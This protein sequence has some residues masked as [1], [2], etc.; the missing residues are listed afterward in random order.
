[1]PVTRETVRIL[2]QMRDFASQQFE[3]EKARIIDGESK[4]DRKERIAD[5]KAL[6]SQASSLRSAAAIAGAITLF[7][8]QDGVACD[9]DAFDRD[10]HLLNLRTG[11]LDLRTGEVR[12]HRASDMVTRTFNADYIPGATAP[13]WEQ[14][15]QDVLPDPEVRAY[16]QRALGYT[17]TGRADQ[18][19]LM[20]LYGPSSTGKTQFIKVIQELFGDYGRNAEPSVF[21]WKR[22]SGGPT[23]ELHALRG[24]RFIATSETS[25]SARM[26]E[27]AIKRITGAD[28]VTSRALY[29]GQKEWQ[30]E[31]VVWMATNFPPM[32]NSDDKAMW[33]R[34]KP[35]HFNV[36]FSADGEPDENGNETRRWTANIYKAL[37]EE[38]PGILN[39]ML[40]G[41]RQFNE[42]GQLGEPPSVTQAM[43]E[44]R[45][46]SDSV[47][48]FLQDAESEGEIVHEPGVQADI[49]NIY[50]LYAAWCDANRIPPLGRR[51]MTNR[52]LARGMV[53]AKS[54][55][56]TYWIGVKVTGVH[57]IRGTMP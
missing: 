45:D 48:S 37:L 26:D 41:L 43:L 7:G 34:V 8:S 54:N 52:M 47:T 42:L 17:L 28:K 3:F 44:Q 23:P 27:E 1:V 4:E 22:D 6:K 18:R 49:R 10:L 39:W 12:E 46:G 57:G 29:E 13:R 25:E 36:L 21:R 31:G 24:A 55:G 33:N 16:V 30:P 14:F 38:A 9:S 2:E 53:Q 40:E 11:T 35:I 51:R 50:V 20:Q 5:A 32:Y 15:L 56:R 19:A